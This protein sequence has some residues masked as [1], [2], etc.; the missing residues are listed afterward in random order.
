[1]ERKRQIETGIKTVRWIYKQRRK[2]ERERERE[3][4]RR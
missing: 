1:M 4:E 3:R 2:R